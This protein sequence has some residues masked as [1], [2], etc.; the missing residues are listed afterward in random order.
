MKT[1][2]NRHS[3]EFVLRSSAEVLRGWGEL[4]GE[5]DVQNHLL[6]GKMNAAISLNEHHHPRQRCF[7]ASDR[8]SNG[9]PGGLALNKVLCDTW[10]VSEHPAL[11]REPD[12]SLPVLCVSL[13]HFE[14]DTIPRGTS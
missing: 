4:K 2:G 3:G 8:H 14:Q 1:T 11:S 10:M 5:Y 12:V 6:E 7:R 9:E 13:N